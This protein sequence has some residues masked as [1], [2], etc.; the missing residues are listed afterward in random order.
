MIAAGYE[1]GNDADPLRADPMFKLALDRAGAATGSR[2]RGSRGGY[3]ARQRSLLRLGRAL[4]ELYCTS[5]FHVPKRI[6][7]IDHTF[8]TAHGRPAVAPVQCPS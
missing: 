7:N 4:V 5:F 6:V 2:N 3:H 1:D 8:Y